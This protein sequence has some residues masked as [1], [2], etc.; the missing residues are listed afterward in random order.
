[1]NISRRVYISI[2]SAKISSHA[3]QKASQPI[4]T[5]TYCK[6][7]ITLLCSLMTKTAAMCCGWSE[8]STEN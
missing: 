3:L 1:M 4:T 6:I 5:K 7:K 2:Y 8:H